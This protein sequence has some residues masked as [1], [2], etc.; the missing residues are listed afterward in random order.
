M[1]CI[2][3]PGI[4]TILVAPR[5]LSCLLMNALELI[6]QPGYLHNFILGSYHISKTL[7]VCRLAQDMYTC[8]VFLK[9]RR[10]GLCRGLVAVLD[11]LSKHGL[12]IG[13]LGIYVT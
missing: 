10:H 9:R 4:G 2:V 7:I 6:Q 12:V 13:P 1:T 8:S 11:M 5:R 3:V